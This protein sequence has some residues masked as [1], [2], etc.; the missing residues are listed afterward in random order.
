MVIDCQLI[1]HIDFINELK[2]LI[3]KLFSTRRP[4]RSH[5]IDIVTPGWSPSGEKFTYEMLQFINEIYMENEL[6]VYDHIKLCPVKQNMNG[7]G[8][9][10]HPG[11]TISE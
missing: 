5:N 2:H 6:A 1:F 7:L 10:D 11:V 8:L 4:S 9:I 3:G